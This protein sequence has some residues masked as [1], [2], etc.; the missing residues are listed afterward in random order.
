[1]G[2]NRLT[3]PATARDLDDRRLHRANDID[4]SLLQVLRRGGTVTVW[5]EELSPE[6][7]PDDEELRSQ[8]TNTSRSGSAKDG[9][10]RG[11]RPMERRTRTPRVRL[12]GS[13]VHGRILSHPVAMRLDGT[14]GGDR[15]ALALRRG[16]MAHL[17]GITQL[18]P[19][20]VLWRLPPDD[21]AGELGALVAL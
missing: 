3:L 1:A 11:W 9:D 5:P 21:L 14:R 2:T 18:T 4:D 16:P 20:P 8:P 6:L 12:S 17:G 10:P 13:I 7:E 15:Q 19:H